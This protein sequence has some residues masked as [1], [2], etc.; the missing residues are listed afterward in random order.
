MSDLEVDVASK[1]THPFFWS[2]Y[3]LRESFFEKE[4]ARGVEVLPPLL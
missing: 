2:L 4:R 3:P 1:K